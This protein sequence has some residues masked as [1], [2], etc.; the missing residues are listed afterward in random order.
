MRVLVLLLG[1]LAML[2]CVRKS[3]MPAQSVE[4][5]S[6]TEYDMARDF[7]FKGETRLALDHIH[8]AIQLD[9]DNSKAH[10]FAASIH[11][12]FCAQSFRSPDCRLGEAESF[13]RK[14]MSADPDFRDARNLLGQVLILENKHKDA[15]AVL[16]PLTRDMAYSANHL[17]W[18]NYGWAQ[19][20]AGLVDQ[21]IVSLKNSVTQP[22][23]CVGYYRLGFAYEKKNDTL[24]AEDA[25]SHALA[26]ETP[27]CQNLQDAWAARAQIR[28]KQGRTEEAASDFQRCALISRDTEAGRMCAHSGSSGVAIAD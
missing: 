15:M 4:R 1:S 9:S 24:L 19:V 12:S 16:E 7:Y 18:G 13:A 28:L 3:D 8:R 26:V 27:E 21:G 5:Q 10:Y 23:F 14:A 17:A 22:R 11:L 2:G 20:K 25:Y 6:E